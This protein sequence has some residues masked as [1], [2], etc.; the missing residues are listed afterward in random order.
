MVEILPPP[1]GEIEAYVYIIEFQKRGLPHAHALFTLKDKHK[2]LNASEIDRVI[3][4]QIPDPEVFCCLG[5][6]N[7]A[8]FRHLHGYIKQCVVICSMG[9]TMQI[10]TA[11]EKTNGFVFLETK[12]SLKHSRGQYEIIKA[13]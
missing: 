4:A 10:Q 9:H 1:F 8:Y 13:H 3:S 6:F 7:H 2:L 11:C 12:A 5:I